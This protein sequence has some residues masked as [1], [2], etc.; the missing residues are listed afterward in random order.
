MNLLMLPVDVLDAEPCQMVG[1][2]GPRQEEIMELAGGNGADH[3]VLIR[4][5]K[6][7]V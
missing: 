3:A 1:E 7:S 2:F 4:L 5:E 6:Q